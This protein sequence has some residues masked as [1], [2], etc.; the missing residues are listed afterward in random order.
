MSLLVVES[1]STASLWPETC[2]VDESVDHRN[3][4]P[5]SQAKA[6]GSLYHG[7]NTSERHPSA[8]AWDFKV[9][10]SGH[11]AIG[12]YCCFSSRAHVVR[13]PGPCSE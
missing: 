9:Q 3:G 13:Y 4:R 8:L 1:D 11:L 2:A 7:A 6:P 10:Q 12:D 5:W